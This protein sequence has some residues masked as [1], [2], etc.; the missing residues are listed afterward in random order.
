V[1][2]SPATFRTFSKLVAPL[3]SVHQ[4][5]FRGKVS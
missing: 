3:D 5:D 2:R 4:T 1:R